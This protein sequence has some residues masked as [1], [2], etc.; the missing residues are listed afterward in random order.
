M[1][2]C[3]QKINV[4]MYAGNGLEFGMEVAGYE[5]FEV[6]PGNT[7][8]RLTHQSGET[9]VIY[10]SAGVIVVHEVPGE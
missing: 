2:T 5:W 1:A 8:I 9:T 10:A 6:T 3:P 7:A 4:R